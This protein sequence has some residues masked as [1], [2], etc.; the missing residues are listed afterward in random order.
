MQS[1]PS[2]ANFRAVTPAI[3]ASAKLA[4]SEAAPDVSKAEVAITLKK[5]A[6]VLGIDG[7]A[8]Q[9]LD[10]LLGLSR[11]SDWI[12]EARPVV[13]ISNQKL[14]EYTMRSQRTVIRCI[15]KLVEAGIVAYRDS[16]TGRR[17]VYRGEDGAPLAAYGLDFTPA[18]IRFA[19]LKARAD[20]FKADLDRRR[21]SQRT[22]TRRARAIADAI[23]LL[24]ETIADRVLELRDAVLE[25]SED[26]HAKAEKLEDLY[27]E[28]L[29]MIDDS[30]HEMPPEG[31][32]SVTSYTNTTPENHRKSNQMRT[33]SNERDVSKNVGYAADS[34]L[35]IK[36]EKRVGRS[37]QPDEAMS[38]GAERASDPKPVPLGLLSAAT[39]ETQ[40]TLSRDFRSWNDVI[41]SAK[42]MRVMVGLSEAGWLDATGRVGPAVAAAILA[43]VM[44]KTYRKGSDLSSPGGYF[45]AMIDR[46][47][48]G[49]LHLDRTLY[50]LAN[51]NFH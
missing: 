43:T 18:R 29:A 4:Q 16:P 11:S 5:A 14:A 49:N 13:A 27:I 21:E 37:T 10:I 12:G 7:T 25:S 32:I 39:R 40:S 50:G 42:V 3:L 38:V 31:D 23:G 33:R 15:R 6:P 9:I 1:T 51:R 17:Y 8:Y 41:D 44:E 46:T 45:R 20:A 2:V 36:Q 28:T 48:S 19:E 24:D 47:V 26:I 35:E 34:A 22:V 30:H